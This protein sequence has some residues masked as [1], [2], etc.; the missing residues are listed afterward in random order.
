MSDE[1]LSKNVGQAFQPAT[2]GLTPECQLRALTHQ[3]RGH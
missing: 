3:V 1:E 2:L